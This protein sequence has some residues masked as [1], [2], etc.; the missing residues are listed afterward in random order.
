[1][2]RVGRGGRTVG[3]HFPGLAEGGAVP[4]A[5]FGVA[6]GVGVREAHGPEEGGV[7]GVV[8]VHVGGG[9]GLGGE[10]NMEEVVEARG[11]GDGIAQEEEEN[12]GLAGEAGGVGGDDLVF[13]VVGG[14]RKG[15]DLSL[16]EVVGDESHG[17]R[18]PGSGP[19]APTH[20]GAGDLV[21]IGDDGADGKGAGTRLGF[22]EGR[23]GDVRR[24]GN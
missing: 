4:A 5:E 18:L 15:A 3:G 23:V 8:E 12:A 2:E 22:V 16:E 24:G 9:G 21:R 10:R 1:M 20:G 7:A 13:E 14:S 17:G 11:V 19:A 6:E